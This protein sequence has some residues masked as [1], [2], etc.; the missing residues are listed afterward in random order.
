MKIVEIKYQDGRRYKVAIT[1]SRS[2]KDRVLK[3]IRRMQPLIIEVKETTV[4][5]TDLKTF[6]RIIEN[7]V[8]H[9]YKNQLTAQQ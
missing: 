3:A 8:N 9:E 4:G 5:I 6:E 2:Q 1:D 7:H